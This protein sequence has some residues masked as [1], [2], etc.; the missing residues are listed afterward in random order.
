MSDL[1]PVGTRTLS[2]PLGRS[3]LVARPQLAERLAEGLRHALTLISAPAGFGKTTL[4]SAWRAHARSGP[5]VVWV[6]LDEEDN[7]L[8]RFVAHLIGACSTWDATLGRSAQSLLNRPQPASAR[9]VLMALVHDLEQL[10]EPVALALDDY[11]LI[12]ADAVHEALAYLLDHLGPNLRLILLTR[13]DPPLPL[14]RLRARGELVEIRAADLRF[15]LADTTTLLN[16]QLGL[17]LS[18]DALASLDARTEGWVTGLHLAALSLRDR[19]AEERAAF[20]HA[21]SGSQRYIIDFLTEEVL[22]QEP[23]PIRDF[24]LATSIP[25]RLC[26]PLC[27]ALLTAEGAPPGSG[28]TQLEALERR[29]LF[30]TALDPERR[31][32]R[33]HQLF[34]DVLARRLETEAPDRVWDLHERASAWFE[35]AGLIDEAVQHALLARD[36]TRAARLIAGHGCEMIMR[37]EV[38]TLNK[39]LATLG[40]A[41]HSHPWLIIQKAWALCVLGQTDQVERL[42]RTADAALAALEP[43][44]EVRIMAGTSVAARAYAAAAQGDAAAAAAFARQTLAVLPTEPGFAQAMRSVATW[45]LGDSLQLAGD[46]EDAGSVY[47]EAARISAE[48]GN[49]SMAIVATTSLGDVL[50]AQGRLHRAAQVYTEALAQA[51][52]PDGRRAP[53]ADRILCGLSQIAY[54]WDR[55]EV[56]AERADECL[57]VSTAWDNG[58][59][60]AEAWLLRALIETAQGCAGPALDALRTAERLLES[61]PMSGRR[62]AELESALMRVWIWHAELDPPLRFVAAGRLS[63]AD[64]IPAARVADYLVL[65][66]LLL[67]QGDLTGADA[68]SA[69]LLER[70]EAGPRRGWTI[71]AQILRALVLLAQRKS[72]A[73]LGVLD[74]ALA[75]AQGEGF[76]RVFLDEGEPLARLLA[77]ARARSGEASFAARLLAARA[78]PHGE[79]PGGGQRLVEPLTAREREVLALIEAGHSNLAIAARLV[80]ALPTVK[81][82]VSTIY[83]KLGVASRTQAIARAR[84]LAL[85][86]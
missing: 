15:D 78:L 38:A 35:Q 60:Q 2:A 51:T 81:R 11:H 54:A 80:V 82:H 39:W 84:E 29:N 40:L 25:G 4:V 56:A 72:D 57:T 10:A 9:S 7:D 48:A 44:S 36:S 53:L 24:L 42:L 28:Q 32:F 85:L 58:E 41:A 19:S 67:A 26:G 8:V 27:E 52:R 23:D 71:E 70:T 47:R 37:G 45:I 17:N 74:R 18:A 59:M 12:V 31:W 34:R 21:F 1:G 76:V 22:G 49:P 69:H 13:T 33:Y 55:L 83:A 43:T 30:L 63:P 62:A 46:L 73:A 50:L 77:K 86:A 5:A 61:V 66:R 14:A 64:E 65:L 6:S 75:G 16:D 68:L 20:V 79:P 3:R